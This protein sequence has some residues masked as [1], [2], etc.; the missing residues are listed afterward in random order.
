MTVTA[1]LAM[2]LDGYIAGP[3][4][5]LDNP[6]GDGAEPL[7]EWIHNLAS[8][9]ERQGMSGGEENR[10][11]ELM[12]EWFDATGAVV[13]G[14]MMYDTGEEFW[15]DN[16]PFRTPVFVLTHRPRPTLV[17]EGGTTFTFVS[18]GIH[19]ALQQAK[20]AAGERNVDIAGG[21]STVRQYLDAGLVDELQLHVVP[22][23]LGD[24]LR[25][26]GG[27]EAGRRLEVARVVDTPLATHLKYRFVK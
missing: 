2:S 8:W 1:D 13:M 6:G 27:L 5:T 15:G 21:A 26:F 24:G 20:A 14:R 23:L 4:V 17:K 19:S 18:E 11:S 3:N 16:P 22:A 10:D 12:R 7:F 25:L 9:R